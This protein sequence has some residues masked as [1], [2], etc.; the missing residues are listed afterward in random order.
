MTGLREAGRPAP[1]SPGPGR[2]GGWVE[3]DPV[4]ERRFVDLGPLDLERGGSLPAVRVAYQTWGPPGGQPVLVE[5]ALTG[6]SHVV[7][8]TGPGQPT[9]GWWD[10]LIGDGA[11]LDPARHLVVC[12]N[13]LG[14]CQGDARV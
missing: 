8:S 12:A 10:G 13:V 5:H 11:P 7:G 2:S 9:P 3:G 6:D 14:G 4:G 1:A